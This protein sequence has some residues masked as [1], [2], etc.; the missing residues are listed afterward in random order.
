MPIH[1]IVSDLDDTL[2]REDKTLSERSAATLARAQRAGAQLI[3]ASGRTR[4]SM[5]RYVRQLGVTLPIIACNG[6][7]IA[8]ADTGEVLSRHLIDTALAQEVC[9]LAESLGAYIQTYAGDHFYFPEDC[10]YSQRY[11]LTSGMT[12]VAVGQPLSRYLTQPTV[13][14]LLF[15]EP[16]RVAEMLPL[17][18]KQFAGRLNCT[19]SQPYYIEFAHPEATKGGAL[20][21]LA[22]RLGIARAN[23]C[24][25]GDSQ[26]D[27][28]MLAY[29]GTGVAVGNAI[30]EVK[31]QV[32]R[33]APS[34]LDDGVAQVVEQLL[35]E[36][37]I[38]SAPHKEVCP[39]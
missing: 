26:N 28:S 11:T 23:I 6:A 10:V 22:E 33:V 37:L 7:E 13:K 31:R 39:W 16:A 3:L 19:I 29:A 18:C 38:E 17:F 9:R 24:A 35:E 14:L 1:L 27:L 36:G 5:M 25:F 2:L 15:D 20:R 30:D 32:T 21:L 12:G 8:R 4:I 34:N